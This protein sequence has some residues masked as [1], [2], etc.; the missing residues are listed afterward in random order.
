MSFSTLYYD[1]FTKFN[2][3][4]DDAFTE[5]EQG[6]GGGQLARRTRRERPLEPR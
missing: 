5:R 3:L 1:P 4:L 2:R 6:T